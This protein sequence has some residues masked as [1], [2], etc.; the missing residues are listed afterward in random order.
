MHLEFFENAELP[1]PDMHPDK[2]GNLFFHRCRA[3][4]DLICFQN[5]YHIQR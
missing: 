2:F 1:V 3:F 4:C 5:V